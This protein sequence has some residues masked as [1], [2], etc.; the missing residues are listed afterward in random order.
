[1]IAVYHR[2]STLHNF[3]SGNL[4][5]YVIFVSKPIG[6]I[7]NV[8]FFFF[9]YW[10]VQV[11]NCDNNIN[12]PFLK[13]IQGPPAVGMFCHLRLPQLQDKVPLP[14]QFFAP[15]AAPTARQ[16]PPVVGMFCPYSKARSPCLF[17]RL[18]LQHDK[19]PL[20]LPQFPMEEAC[21]KRE[22]IL[23]VFGFLL[24]FL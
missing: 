17:P 3:I 9:F 11:F 23:F 2:R 8:I 5:K 1:M 13:T 15:Q 10:R 6:V 24:C 21:F 22:I 19:V 7:R 4:K 20:L 14:Q 12:K 18:P 16:G